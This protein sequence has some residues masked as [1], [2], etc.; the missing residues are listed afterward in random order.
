M[1]I[2]LKS[3]V[4]KVDNIC[5]C[6]NCVAR[7]MPELRVLDQEDNTYDYIKLSELFS[8]GYELSDDLNF[9]K[10]ITHKDAIDFIQKQ[11]DVEWLTALNKWI[12]SH[13]NYL[14]SIEELEKYCGRG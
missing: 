4:Y 8:D 5:M 14:K 10:H 3:K 11:N 12:N 1:F 13:I 7:K 9:S 2:R 6:E